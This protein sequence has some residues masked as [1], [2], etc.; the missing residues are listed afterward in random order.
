MY[1]NKGYKKR[2][3]EKLTFYLKEKN[4]YISLKQNNQFLQSNLFQEK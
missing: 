2:G 1:K 4:V 3:I